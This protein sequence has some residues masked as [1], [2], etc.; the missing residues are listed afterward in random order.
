MILLAA[1]TS[2]P[3]GSLALFK[4]KNHTDDIS[5]NRAESHSE[6]LTKNVDLLLSRNQISY[7]DIDHFAVGVGPGSF[8]GLRVALNFIRTSAFIHNK[9][10]LVANSHE[11]IAL[12]QL[13]HFE[14][15]RVAITA[16]RNLIYV[17]DFEKDTSGKLRTLLPPT[18]ISIEEFENLNHE[19][20]S[21][22]GDLALIYPQVAKLKSLSSFENVLRPHSLSF[23][24]LYLGLPDQSSVI[25]W[26]DLAPLY[27][28]ASE[29]EEKL[30]KK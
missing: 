23:K 30:L 13:S 14:K 12:S 9:P 26:Q 4:D 17:A 29:A 6:I 10:V 18:A 8:T 15:F 24:E 28:R 20:F 27:V 22:L 11:L 1:D 2:S 16:F 3:Q 21:L 5:W 25:P 7:S 19:N